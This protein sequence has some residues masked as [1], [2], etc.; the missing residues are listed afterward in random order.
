[1]AQRGPLA[2]GEMTAGFR[3]FY[4]RARI[5]SRVFDYVEPARVDRRPCGAMS[6]GAPFGVEGRAAG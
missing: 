2:S 4:T 5:V 6:G 1:M 3:D